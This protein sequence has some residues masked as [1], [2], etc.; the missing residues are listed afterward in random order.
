M[1]KSA[2]SSNYQYVGEVIEM[3]LL[4]LAAASRQL[5]MCRE[6]AKKLLASVP[7]VQVR[8]NG[9]VMYR[10]DVL[11]DYIRCGGNRDGASK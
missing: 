5:G 3:R 6:S 4:T 9:R 11:I 1:S 7:E 8:T 2:N 10:H